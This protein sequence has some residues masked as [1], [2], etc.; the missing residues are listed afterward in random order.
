MTS[1]L[2]KVNQLLRFA[3]IWRPFMIRIQNNNRAVLVFLKKQ[4]VLAILPTGFLESLAHQSFVVAKSV[5]AAVV[6]IV[7]I[8][9]SYRKDTPAMR[10]SLNRRIVHTNLGVRTVFSDFI[11]LGF[12]LI[13]Q[14]K[15]PTLP[16]LRLKC[17]IC[18][19]NHSPI[20]R[21]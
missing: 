17:S 16:I 18:F 13:L 14:L 19:R 20:V 11:P 9:M 3:G 2:V 12:L 15:S 7:I 4:D 8:V 1:T 10:L 21:F 5:I 6:P